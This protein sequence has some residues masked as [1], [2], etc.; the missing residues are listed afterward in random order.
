MN[1]IIC[2]EMTSYANRLSLLLTMTYAEFDRFEIDVVEADRAGDAVEEAFL[3]NEE[4]GNSE[5]ETFDNDV[6]EQVGVRVRRCSS[7][8]IGRRRGGLVV[9]VAILQRPVAIRDFQAAAGGVVGVT[10]LARRED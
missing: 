10:G 8:A 6:A 4:I 2:G 1:S 7:L 5:E 9:K 3:A